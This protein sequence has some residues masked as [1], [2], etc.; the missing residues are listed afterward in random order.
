MS[1]AIR[2]Q[3][4]VSLVELMVA[5]LLLAVALMGQAGAFVPGRPAIQ[6]VD[7]ATPRRSW[8]AWCSRT[9]AIGYDLS[10]VSRP[11]VPSFRLAA[12]IQAHHFGVYRTSSGMGARS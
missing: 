10:T 3:C 9:C 7:Q 6:A 1:M 5:L 4:G 11:P 8:P 2:M 12:V